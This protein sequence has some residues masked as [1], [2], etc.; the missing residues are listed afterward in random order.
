MRGVSGEEQGLCV[1]ILGP[2]PLKVVVVVVVV[3]VVPPHPPVDNEAPT[4]DE[5]SARSECFSSSS[6][7]STTIPAAVAKPNSLSPLAYVCIPA[8]TR[9]A[10]HLPPSLNYYYYYYYYGH[11]P[12]RFRSCP[13]ATATATLFFF[14]PLRLRLRLRY[15]PLVGWLRSKAKV[16][17]RRRRRLEDHRLSI[18]PSAN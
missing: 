14:Y 3:V 17:P 9:F 1:D 8:L 16:R 13:L 11:Q 6:I 18:H 7:V 2:L 4:N 10:N 15:V 5:P 12:P